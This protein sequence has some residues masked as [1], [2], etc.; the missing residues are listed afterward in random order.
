MDYIPFLTKVAACLEPTKGV[1]EFALVD[2]EAWHI[3]VYPKSTV[4]DGEVWLDGLTIRYS[5]LL[6]IFEEVAD[7]SMVDVDG[8]DIVGKF[9]EQEV[10]LHI[11]FHPVVD[12]VPFANM[13]GHGPVKLIQSGGGEDALLN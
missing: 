13:I 11:V 3:L 12:A 5:D 9:Q 4:L 10:C 2:D 6:D 8:L 7:D 1:V